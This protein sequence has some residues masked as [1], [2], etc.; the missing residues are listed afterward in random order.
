[1]PTF[2]KGE[3]RGL[4]KRIAGPPGVPGGLVSGINIEHC[5]ITRVTASQRTNQQ[6]VHTLGNRV[7]LY[8]FGD[9]MGEMGVGGLA[10][11]DC[12]A[13]GHGFQNAAAWYAERRV[14]RNPELVFVTVGEQNFEGFLT[15][16]NMDTSNGDSNLLEFFLTFALLPPPD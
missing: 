16:F 15:G 6:F 10:L 8:V 13:D 2:L 5:L 14:S 7:Y 3:T 1:M 9:R 11:R 12:E 4:V